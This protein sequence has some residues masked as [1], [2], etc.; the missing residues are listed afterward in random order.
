MKRNFTWATLATTL[1]TI[2]TGAA[3]LTGTHGNAFAQQ[4][5]SSLAMADSWQN[6][7]P[8]DENSLHGKVVLVEFWTFNCSNCRN[9]LPYV[10]RWYSTYK[11][12]GLQVIG[13]HSPET[14]SERDPN[15]VAG[16]VRQLG[17]PYPV[18]VDSEMRVWDSFN[19][20]YWPAFYLFDKHGRLRAAHMGE[21]EDQGLER[22]IQE[23][24]KEGDQA[25]LSK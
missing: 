2:V 25:G 21:D 14:S 3:F 17:I 10:K 5:E 20:Q 23:L 19:N 22:K 15:N 18:A 16:E 11:D 24:L 8:L 13:V 4:R 7:P 6:S 9:T 12:Q 1:A